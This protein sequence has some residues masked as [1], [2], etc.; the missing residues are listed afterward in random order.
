MDR[1]TENTTLAAFM[2]RLFSAAPH[3]SP[4]PV[5]DIAVAISN[6]RANDDV[7]TPLAKTGRATSIL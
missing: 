7:Q 2:T 3:M 4:N 1:P 6:F 5:L